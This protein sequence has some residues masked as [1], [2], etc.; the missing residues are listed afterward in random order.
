M[1]YTALTVLL[2][3]IL[4]HSSSQKDPHW[5]N[6]RN[7]IVHLFEWKW[8]DI[9][10]ECER[11][12]QHKGYAGVQVSPPNEHLVLPE[13]PWWDRYQPISYTLVS[14]SGNESEFANMVKRCNSV[15]V[16][17]YVDAVINHMSGGVQEQVGSAGNI[18]NPGTLDYPAVPYSKWDFHDRC[19]IE[20]SD[21]Q[22]NANDV[23][24]CYLVGLSDLNQGND[25]VRKK[26]VEYLNHLVDLGVAGFRIDAAKHMWPADLHFI[27]SNIKN[28]NTD[29]GFRSNSKPFI[30][31]EVIDSGG[32][33]VSK[34][35]YTSLGAVTEFKYSNEISRV[36][37]GNDKLTYLS[38]WGE[39]WGFLKSSDAFIFVDNHDNQRGSNILTYKEP[40]RYKMAVAF[41]LA[42]P[43]G[44][45]RVM[46]SFDFNHKDQ[47]PPQDKQGHLISPTINDD[48]TCGGGWVCE[49]RWRQI[50]NMVVFKNAVRG[51]GLN[52]W[53]SNGDQ[54]IAFCRGDKGFV[55]FTNWGDLDQR[56]QTC[57]PAGIYCDVISGNVD[58]NGQCTG[59]KVHVGAD[60]TAYIRI[61]YS[62]EDRVLAI[63][64]NSKQ[65]LKP[66]L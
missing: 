42:Y 44:I 37:K 38:S 23:R 33:A 5:L 25:Y 40:Q 43:Y 35:E 4:Q 2:L 7:T 18:G 45:S 53:W 64:V 48:D 39:G 47:G 1:K 63:H 8:S 66:K 22:H 13:H 21:Y 11:F 32:E 6:D 10:D 29:F 57:L 54:Q 55:A 59:E 27:Y 60:G 51:T 26:I 28:L 16:R 12:L 56:L 30:Y 19:E 24:N 31:Q 58:K 52:N 46:S 65:G 20:G 9:A 3:H 41:M 17:I 50:Y 62:A 36:F 15:G 49:H 14:R 34:N 61:N